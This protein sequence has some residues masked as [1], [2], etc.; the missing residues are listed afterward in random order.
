MRVIFMILTWINWEYFQNCQ[1]FNQR[2]FHV[3]IIPGP[4]THVC[5]NQNTIYYC[6]YTK[7]LILPSGRRRVW[8]IDESERRWM[9]WLWDQELTFT[10]QNWTFLR[11]V[12][13]ESHIWGK[14]KWKIMM[15]FSWR[16]ERHEAS[17]IYI[18]LRWFIELSFRYHF[19]YRREFF[20]CFLRVCAC[21]NVIMDLLNIALV[22]MTKNI[23]KYVG[24]HHA[25]KKI[26]TN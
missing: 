4:H 12:F 25:S 9:G 7:S 11:N 10:E 8:L 23:I 3:W 18:D 21:E 22:M 2:N 15:N 14:S 5:F 6:E 1:K 17:F 19:F 16:H 26:S 24:C 13:I 20:I